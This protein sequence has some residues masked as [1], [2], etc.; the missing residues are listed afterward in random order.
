[1]GQATAQLKFAHVTDLTPVSNAINATITSGLTFNFTIDTVQN[2]KR[3]QN[4][5]TAMYSINFL[6][7][8]NIS[9][10]IM[11]IRSVQLD[12]TNCWTNSTLTYDVNYKNPGFNISVVPLN[13]M[14]SAAVSV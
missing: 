3:I 5:K 7:I 9:G 2:F 10:V 12:S 11:K 4:E 8:L 13:C 6:Q 14:I 1:M